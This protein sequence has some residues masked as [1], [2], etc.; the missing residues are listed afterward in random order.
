MLTPSY[1]VFLLRAGM[2]WSVLLWLLSLSLSGYFHWPQDASSIL[3]KV[4]ATSFSFLP[5]ECRSV[6][7][8]ISLCSQ[9][10]WTSARAPHTQAALHGTHALSEVGCPPL[11]LIYRLSHPRPPSPLQA[12]PAC[13]PLGL[14]ASHIL[15]IFSNV[16]IFNWRI[17]ALQYCV[18]FCHTSTW[19][20]HRYTYA[21][22]L[23]NLP[24]TSP[25]FWS[26]V[27]WFT[28]LC[29]LQVYSIVSQCFCRLYS[30]IGYYK[31]MAIIFHAIQYILVAA[32]SY[33]LVCISQV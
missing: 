14:T 24:P 3:S 13:L 11:S 28:I 33:I 26:A 5:P 12:P 19:I 30:I 25:C 21:P 1:F 16:F 9:T 2:F 17:I 27:S 7:G 6:S 4:T 23:L 22:S 15:L 20:S 8:C 31:I 10:E 29:Q 32:V 18:G